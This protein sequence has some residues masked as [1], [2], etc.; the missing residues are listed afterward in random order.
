MNHR[1]RSCLA[2][3]PLLLTALPSLAGPAAA[4]A[5]ADKTPATPPPA[6]NPLSFFDGKLIFDVQLKN[7]MESRENNFDFN[8]SVDSLTDDTWFLNRARLGMK[9]S[10]LP[11]LNFYVQGQDVREWDSDRPNIIGN[12]GAEG[13]DQFDLRQGYVEIG[14]AKKGVS[15]KIGRQIFL[16]GD[17][18]LVGPLD[19]ANQGRTFDAARVRYAEEK[20]W[21]EAFASSVVKFTDGEFNESDWLDDAV[22]DQTFSGVYF[23]TT[24]IGKQT[25]DFY[26]FHLSED[27]AAG[28]SDFF[29][30]GTRMKSTPGAFNGWDYDTEMAF[31]TGD[32]RGMDLSSFAGHWGVG[33]TWANHPWKPRLGIEY[34]YATGDGNARDGEVETFQNLFPTNHKFYGYMDV[35]S[36]QN[37]HNVAISL[38]ATPM[39][40]LKVQAD[41]QMFWLA[42][43]SDGWYRA[44]GTTLVRPI[45][46]GAD[47][48]AGTE[49]DLTIN[50]KA[51][52]NL[53]FQAGYSHFFAGSYLGD[54]GAE[55]DADFVYVQAQLDL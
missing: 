31:Q 27:Y 1:Y 39:K 22:R 54:T 55:D 49:F 23:S 37:L 52:K 15:A 18:R 30:F 9:V 7:R 14:N 11:Y 21:V 5:P 42:D 13:D 6:P 47:S 51:T 12:M 50:Y 29:T 45:T 8:D 35:F 33:Y 48:Y 10:P 46:P 36:W 53:S 34:N 20:W 40:K 2:A 28:D 3:F 16:Y 41:L 4:P 26:V 43:T 32:V 25:T 44:N 38:S 17:E 24:A 19:W